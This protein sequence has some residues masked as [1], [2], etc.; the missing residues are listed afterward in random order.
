M[1][2]EARRTSTSEDC[3]L[4][5]LEEEATHVTDECRMIL[6]GVQA[7]LGFQLIA[8]FNARFD[9]FNEVE[10]LVHLVAFLLVMSAMGLIMA[11]AA[12][13]RQAER[14]R[15]TRRFVNLAS[16]LLTVAMVPFLMGVSLDTYLVARLVST[17]IPISLFIAAGTFIVLACLWVGLPAYCRSRNQSR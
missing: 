4:E 8:V 12:L 6:P 14:G 5:T 13:H 2:Q 10:Q 11:P 16:V 9:Q 15:V 7:I 17:Q 3:H 1:R